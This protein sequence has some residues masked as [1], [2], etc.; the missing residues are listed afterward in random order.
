MK[1]SLYRYIARIQ[2]LLPGFIAAIISLGVW[3]LGGWKALEQVGYNS[4]FQIR[5]TGILPKPN[6]D[7][8]VA[9]IAIDEASLRKLGR[10]PF[11]RD[12]YTKLL[13]TLSPSRPAAV[14]LDIIF[15]EASPDDSQLADAI[16][17]SGNVIVAQAWDDQEQLIPIERIIEEAVAS[18][19]HIS[20]NPDTDGI[21]R[22]AALKFR[23]LP[24]LGLAMLELYSG[25]NPGK[26]EQ[27]ERFL[28]SLNQDNRQFNRVWLNWPGKTQS[29][30]TYSFAD[31]LEGKVDKNAFTGKLVLVG[32]TATGFDPLVTPL[33]Q[34]PPTSGVYL[35]AAA[36]DNLLNN[37]LLQTLPDGKTAILL[38]LIGP[39][40][41]GILSKLGVGGRVAI[42]LILPLAW[43]GFSL[44]LFSFNSWLLPIAAPVGTILL[45]AIGLEL[46]EQQEKQQLMSLFEKYM[47][48]ETANL[49]W[50]R[51]D[52]IIKN[53]ELQPQEMIATVLFMDIR[54]FTTIS[55]QLSPR[56]LMPWLNQYLNAMS[57]CIM[58]RGGVIDKYIGD[59]IMAIFGIPF[60]R[61]KPEEIKQDALNCMAACLEMYKRLQK[62]NQQFEA[63]RKPLIKFGI[64]V[65]TGSIIA[66]SVGGGQ[67]LNFS[68]LGDTVNVAARL[69][70]MNKEVKEDNP[71]GILITNET[72]EY[73]SDRYDAKPVKSIQL[74]GRKQETIICSILG[75][76]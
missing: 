19:G 62:L 18:R 42:A 8:R 12:R 70:A 23:G 10:F 32:I 68:V 1:N 73:V 49:I 27:L 67:R 34:M 47:A 45:A 14:G 35:H 69:E 76:K 28:T 48:K 3:Q 56:E 58:N 72:W 57:E 64:G 39:I 7:N 41:S 44:T 24:S 17:A 63:E 13:Q 36:I 61:N 65:H 22:Q 2:G 25:D 33:N 15:A 59:A 53:G 4:L 5:D 16:R 74:R 11:S 51:K 66:G 31:V 71:Y 52:E 30:Q 9:V 75:K 40:A 29:L 20:H 38:L 50:Q 21:S 54:G 26:L 60:P 37:R 6:W 55:E 46:R 43:Y